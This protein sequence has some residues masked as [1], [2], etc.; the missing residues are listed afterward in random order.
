LAW[1]EAQVG[2]RGDLFSRVLMS[3]VGEL[4]KDTWL[5]LK[6]PSVG[7]CVIAL[8]HPDILKRSVIA[9][10]LQGVC[11]SS[12]PSDQGIIDVAIMILDEI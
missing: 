11:R 5:G 4:N 9:C 8:W 1:D 10:V 7:H 3:D 12:Q 6:C 2:L